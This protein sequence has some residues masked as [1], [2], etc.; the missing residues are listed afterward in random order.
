M[1][2]SRKTGG[3]LVSTP[4]DD[5]LGEKPKKSKMSRSQLRA[6]SLLGMVGTLIFAAVYLLLAHGQTT[7]PETD[8]TVKTRIDRKYD[9]VDLRVELKLPDGRTT[10]V[11]VQQWQTVHGVGQSVRIRYD[12]SSS[13]VV[14]D[15]RLVEEP[16][17]R[18]EFLIGPGVL[19]LFALGAGYWSWL[20][21]PADGRRR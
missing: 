12:L 17:L 18:K 1:F 21:M 9:N 10:N 19:F 16:T 20:R 4:T 5:F 14:D 15:A 13:G 2:S 11:I 7:W 6:Y 8:A 3:R